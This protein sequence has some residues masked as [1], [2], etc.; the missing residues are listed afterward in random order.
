MASVTR[1]QFIKIGAASAG[2][3]TV[4]SGLST[5]WWG[6]DGDEVFDPKSDG[7][8]II[9]TFCELCFWKC[10]VLAHVKNGRVTKIKGNPAHPLSRGRLC[11][12]GT[13]G[14]G[15]LYDPD[16]LKKPLLRTEKRGAQRF[17]EVSW[18][19]AL[20]KISESLLSIRKRYGPEVVALFSHGY[21]GSWFKHLLKAYGS[22]NIAAPSYA[23]CRGPREVGFQL[24]FGQGL[25]SPEPLDI[26]NARCI[27]MIG[28]HLG[29]NMHN[30]QVQD[31]AD[32]IGKGAELVVVDPRYSTVAG[33]ARYWLPIKPG[34]DIALL[35]AWMHVVITEKLYDVDYVTKHTKGFEELKKHVADKTPEWAYAITGLSPQLIR[36]SG[37]FIASQRPASLIH[38]GR[39][40]TW[41]GDDTQRLRSIAILTALLGAWGR[42]GGYILP[43]NMPVPAFPY[44]K[45]AHKPKGGADKPSPSIFPLADE[46]LAS[47]LC[48]ATIPAKT[49][50]QLRAWLVYGTN[51]LQSLPNPQETIKAIQA[52]DFIA[53]IDVLPA[54]IC[55]WADV[56]LPESTYLERCDELWNPSYEQPF[57][58]VRQQVVKPMYDSKPGWEI[59]K[60]LGQ[61]MGLSDY[62]PWKDSTEYA[63]KRVKAAG[64]DC[65]Q[66]QKTGVALGKRRPVCEEEGLALGFDTPSKKIELYSDALKALGFHPMPEYTP[67]EEPPTG[68]FRLLFGRA[69]AHTFGRTTNNR[70]LSQVYPEN[71]LWINTQAARALAGFESEPLKSGERVVLVNQDGVRS[72]PIRAKVTERIRG[73]CVYMVHGYGHSA[74]GMKFAYQ[75][76]AS[77]S[78]LVT[79]YKTDPIMGGTGMNVNFV[80]LERAPVGPVVKKATQ[81]KATGP[82]KAPAGTPKKVPRAKAKPAATRAPTRAPASAPTSAPTSVP[83]KAAPKAPRTPASAPAKAAAKVGAK[84]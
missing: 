44:T 66:M 2:V 79:R 76:G 38:P 29:E 83:A 8:R 72:L 61:K 3:A 28:S 24:T 47:G 84:A 43:G 60:L 80:R 22:G 51:L 56:V 13:G 25:G 68:M 73:D 54:E 48:D 75:R 77:D 53:V 16:R 20:N 52:L 67:H 11:P 82:N 59:A 55:G 78:E 36:D 32:A 31:L 70:F 49:R 41:Y 5:Q 39:R 26:K 14:T 35:L 33:K 62:F 74:K 7:E 42:R 17:E 58:A 9:P 46:T 27:T 57:V 34:T 50:K 19:A 10:G 65:D 18:D 71:E 23:Q 1:R 81:A 15:L 64:L 30:T 63:M 40:T 21:G 69:P 4:A 45:Y 6:H 12:R 37:R